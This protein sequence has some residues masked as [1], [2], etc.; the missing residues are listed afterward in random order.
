MAPPKRP[1]FRLYVELIW[2]RKIRR[3][4]EKTRWLFV[5][6]LAC[7]RQ[8]NLP[9]FLMLDDRSPMDWDDLCDAAAMRLKDVEKGTDQLQEAGIVDFDEMLRAWFIPKWNERQFESDETTKRTRKHRSKEP[10]RNVPSPDDVT[11]PDTETDKDPPYPP[12]V[13]GRTEGL[14]SNGTNPRAIAAKR[15]RERIESEIAACPDCGDKSYE[16]S[17]CSARRRRLQEVSA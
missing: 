12:Q 5:V 1:W 16:C 9:G 17:R 15:E 8:S 7:A 11:P 2:D 10:G 6:M 14:R 3:L 13:G 4:P